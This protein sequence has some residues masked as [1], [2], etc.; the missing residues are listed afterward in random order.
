MI[1]DRY[2]EATPPP[3]GGDTSHKTLF[4]R[5]IKACEDNPDW[6][7]FVLELKTSPPVWKR[8]NIAILKNQKCI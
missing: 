3:Q 7:T 2:S 1:N 6:R 4:H 5:W 8:D